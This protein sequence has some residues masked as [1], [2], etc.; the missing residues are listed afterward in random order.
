MGKKYK[1]VEESWSFE[2]FS[3]DEIKS[4][5]VSSGPI[6]INCAGKDRTV[7]KAEKET[8][9]KKAADEAAKKEAADK[10]KKEQEA[11]ET[12]KKEK[13]KAQKELAEVC[14]NCLAVQQLLVP[15]QT[16]TAKQAKKAK[17]QADARAAAAR[18]AMPP[19]LL[20]GPVFWGCPCPPPPVIWVPCPP[21]QPHMV[22]NEEGLWQVPPAYRR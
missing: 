10:L 17:E 13:E 2:G 12:A 19:L 18:A 5:K 15:C 14:C 6:N 3:D 4:L 21:Q 9:A 16:D 7:D 20:V 8:D 11:A 1:I 22:W